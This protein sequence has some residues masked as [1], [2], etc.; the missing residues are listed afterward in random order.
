[1]DNQMGSLQQRGW[2][3]H[4]RSLTEHGRSLTEHQRIWA[5]SRDQLAEAVAD[6]GY[7]EEFADLLAK[8]LGSPKAI[9]RLTSYIRHVHPRSVE[10]VVDEMFAI[11]SDIEAWRE[12]KEVEEARAGYNAWLWSEERARDDEDGDGDED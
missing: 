12:K 3:E 5:E 1:M 11:R 8:Q 2:T 7:P 9:D 10:M 6:L 4:E